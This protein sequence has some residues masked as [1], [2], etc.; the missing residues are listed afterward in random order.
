MVRE[1]LPVVED[2]EGGLKKPQSQTQS[3]GLDGEDVMKPLAVAVAV[4]APP[5]VKQL[6]AE[7]PLLQENPHRF[8]LFPIKYHEVCGLD[9]FSFSRALVRVELCLGFVFNG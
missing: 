2:D 6:E 3:K 5:T 9:F 7:E 1:P 8:V 4:A